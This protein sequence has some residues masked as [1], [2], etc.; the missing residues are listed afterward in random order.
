VPLFA[1]TAYLSWARRFYGKVPYD[2]ATSGI[3]LAEV[4]AAPSHAG[5]EAYDDVRKAIARYNDVPDEQVLPVLGTS[6]AIFVAYAAACDRGDELLIETPGYEPLTRAAEGLGLV[7][8]TFERRADEGFAIDV[9]RV[10]AAIG[11]KTRGIVVSSLHNPSGVRVP[12]PSLTDLAARAEARGV[13]LFVDEV[14]APFDT[15]TDGGVFGGSARRLSRN[16]VALGS[17]TKAYGLGMLRL[18]WVLGP[19]EIIARG[20]DVLTA[21]LGHLPLAHAAL[22]KT[23][24]DSIDTYSARTR[25]LVAG[26]RK[27]VESWVATL[28]DAQ[29]S[30]PSEG[31]FG[32]VTLPGRGDLTA[33]IE[34]LAERQ[35]VLVAAGGFFGAPES[36]RLSWATSPL[37][38]LEPALHRL[39]EITR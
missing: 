20:G 27:I 22:G 21:T 36:F 35:G 23:V 37:S 26:K 14:Y 30:A 18:G 4:N 31:L 13:I 12:D 3:P 6:H 33:R 24:L 11:P 28:A 29:W 8:R 38:A 2:L 10:I 34:H 32:M 17:L 16:V 5:L 7:P 15:L 25:A 19:P 39:T 9:E 1:P